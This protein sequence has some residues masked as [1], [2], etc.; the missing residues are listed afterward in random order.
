MCDKKF[1]FRS[2]LGAHK[3]IHTKHFLKDRLKKQECK[4]EEVNNFVDCGETIKVENIKEE[5]N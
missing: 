4:R 1:S 2:T 5:M 3:R